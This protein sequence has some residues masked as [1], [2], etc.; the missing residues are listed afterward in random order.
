MA[1]K[2]A[3][4]HMDAIVQF[5]WARCWNHKLQGKRE[6]HLLQA[7][8]PIHETTLT[9]FFLN[10]FE[11]PLVVQRDWFLWS[12]KALVY[13]FV[14]LIWQHDR[15]SFMWT[16]YLLDYEQNWT[17]LCAETRI[18]WL[19]RWVLGEVPRDMSQEWHRGALCVFSCLTHC[20]ICLFFCV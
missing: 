7:F 3:I 18:T 12:K 9:H 2:V 16:Y 20:A 6:R 14:R 5:F 1:I 15:H 19:C 10:G 4:F 8:P 17:L 11:L 13:H